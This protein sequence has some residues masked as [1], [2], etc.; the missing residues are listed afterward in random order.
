[1]STTSTPLRW[2]IVPAANEGCNRAE[3]HT[4]HTRGV[5]RVTIR[6]PRGGFIGETYVRG[7]LLA[8]ALAHIGYEADSESGSTPLGR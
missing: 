7:Q 4:S 3:V 2:Q 6:G 1:M 5:I 8:N